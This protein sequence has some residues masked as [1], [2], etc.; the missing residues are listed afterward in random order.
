MAAAASI[1]LWRASLEPLLTTPELPEVLVAGRLPGTVEVDT[2]LAE[3]T[4]FAPAAQAPGTNK[5][6]MLLLLL[7][8]LLLLP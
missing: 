1:A 6:G 2:T 4:R 5:G 7:L 3:G 8:L